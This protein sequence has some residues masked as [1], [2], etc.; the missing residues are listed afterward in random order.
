MIKHLF[1][2]RRRQRATRLTRRPPEPMPRIR[3]YS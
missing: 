1:P 3:Y 2:P